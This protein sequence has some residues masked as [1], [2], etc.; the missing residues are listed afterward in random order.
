MGRLLALAAIC[1]AAPA[2]AAAA[3]PEEDAAF[4]AAAAAFDDGNYE[5][6][7]K[8]F[9]QFI[10]AFPS[11]TLLNEVTL[12]QA[13]CRFQLKNYDGVIALLKDRLDTPQYG[14]R[15]RYWLAEAHLNKGDYEAAAREFGRMVTD[16]PGSSRALE[17]SYGQALAFFKLG[18]TQRVVELL[19]PVDGPFQK[20]AR[21]DPR[22]PWTARG[23][24]LFAEALL[25]INRPQDAL[26]ALRRIEPT[27]LQG[28]LEWRHAQLL[29]RG[30]LALN[31]MEPARVAAE[32]AASL[33]A[34][35]RNEEFEAQSVMLLGRVLE[36]TGDIDAA[37]AVYEKNLR[38]AAPLD[39]RRE[40][41]LRIIDLLLGAGRTEQ[42]AQ[43]LE[44]FI[45]QHP[46]DPARDL[47]HLTIG[48]MRLREYYARWSGSLTHTNAALAGP[49]TNLLAQ[50]QEQF[51]RVISG[52]AGGPHAGKALLDRGWCHW[53][54]GRFAESLADFQ[55]AADKLPPSVD[56]LT[57][58]FKLGDAQM[59]LGDARAAMTNYQV[60]VA[61]LPK[62]K[63]ADEALAGQA[64]YQLVNAATAAGE[65][66]AAQEALGRILAGRADH[67]FA[68]PALLLVGEAA[69][70]AGQSAEA[71]RIF[72][73]FFQK[74]PH[75]DRAPEVA[76]AIAR[77]HVQERDWAAS[78]KAYETW[79]QTHT[80]HLLL[81][82][83]V[84]ELGWVNYLAGRDTAA[85]TVFT[86]FVAQYPTSPL[87]P[88]AQNWIAVH[89]FNL[90]VE[91]QVN[92]VKAEEAYLRL[93]Q[94]TNWPVTELTHEAR[95]SAARAAAARQGYK[96]ARGYL[97]NL[98]N[99]LQNT[100]N[101]VLAR[102]FLALGDLLT[103]DP[104]P[105]LP[106]L[107]RRGEAIKAYARVPQ[108]FPNT[109]F[110]ALALGRIGQ[111]YLQLAAL[112]PAHYA[113]AELNLRRLIEFDSPRP[114][115]SVLS[116]AKLSLAAVR[117]R[118][119]QAAGRTPEERTALLKEALDL[120]CEVFYH[121]D[122]RAAEA[123]P[124]PV[125]VQKAGLEAAQLLVALGQLEQ[126]QAIYR[127]LAERFP[128]HREVF[129][130]LRSPA[131]KPPAP[132]PAAAAQA[133]EK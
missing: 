80:N 50:A 37:V 83:A 108:L 65:L 45:Q 72:E 117:E 126:A 43:R 53:A 48:E 33:A 56:Q 20:A 38:Q 88:R 44:Q 76:L 25:G 77:T 16:S 100:T 120:C 3:T 127:R 59:R 74:W 9:A 85:L 98:I 64:L 10:T 22:S 133:A 67:F 15:F 102:A 1:L 109:E 31:Q 39:H 96:E 27:A 51:D 19:Q 73:Q 34:N 95:L 35:T 42:T 116:E 110:H 84:F 129:E 71:R 81:P 94:D 40:A 130:R 132:P 92:F 28:D 89:Y 36:R 66:A 101:P 90:G 119:A 69:N 54:A 75:S 8:R 13:Q 24:L 87:A 99:S 58:R 105:A 125:W 123:Q 106:P 14:D 30:Q 79:T 131:T 103:E 12:R 128:A 46:D 68:Q 6:A 62:V 55:A 112:E 124:D 111:S 121:A 29:A 4:K 91:D 60:V 61:E 93:F 41:L 52:F 104:D 118:Q 97:T 86:N 82:R 47:A 17:G 5:F 63:G 11:S 21:N 57:A 70:D 23:F 113:D 32:R 122:T 78:V 2:G 114:G 49:A 107:E 18:Q 7:E 115:V 26:A